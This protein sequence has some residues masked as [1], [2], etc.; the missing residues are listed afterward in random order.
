LDEVL[1]TSDFIFVVA[2]VTSENQGFLGADAFAGMRKGAAF[3]L[4]SRAGVV[5]FPA[6]MAAVKSGHIVAA[7]DVF[8]EE[9]LARD[10]PVRALPG[11]LRSAH[12]AGALDIAFKRMGD[13]VLEDMDLIDRD[14]PPLRS[15]RAERETVSRMR[16]KPADRY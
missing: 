16:S 6:L 8:P 12:R 11:F 13:M 10:H 1:S 4:L 9:P 7:S 14:L 5:D 15:K 3:I 2:S